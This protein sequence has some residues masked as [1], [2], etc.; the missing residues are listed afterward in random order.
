[1][2]KMIHIFLACI[3]A[4]VF[5]IELLIADDGATTIAKWKDNKKGAFTLRFD[6]SM[7]SHRDHT[8]P[9]L[10]KR[11]L[12]GSFFINPATNRYGYGIDIWE[13]MAGR[14]GLE[15]CPHTMNHTG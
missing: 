10:V 11:G 13:S 5:S 12:V 8:V 2:N 6:D 7:L 15:I 4:F 9:N 14:A 3:L 1:M